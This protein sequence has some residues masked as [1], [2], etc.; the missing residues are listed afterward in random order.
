MTVALVR[1]LVEQYALIRARVV[2]PHSTT[3]VVD[4]PWL[5]ALS[6]PQSN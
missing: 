4:L 2:T 3:L 5:V 6:P 1:H